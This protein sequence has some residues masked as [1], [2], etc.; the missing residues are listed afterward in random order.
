M[1]HSPC[2]AS[3]ASSARA[4]TPAFNNMAE[5]AKSLVVDRKLDRNSSVI[6]HL[7]Y[8]DLFFPPRSSKYWNIC[9]FPQAVLLPFP[10]HPVLAGR[11]P[12][13][14]ISPGTWI[15][16]SKLEPPHC[17]SGCIFCPLFLPLM[18][19]HLL[20]SLRP[21]CIQVLPLSNSAPSGVGHQRCWA[22]FPR[23]RSELQ[24]PWREEQSSGPTA[25]LSWQ[26]LGAN[27]IIPHSYS[28][29]CKQHWKIFLHI[30]IISKWFVFRFAELQPLVLQAFLPHRNVFF[31][32]MMCFVWYWNPSFS[33]MKHDCCQCFEKWMQ[34][35]NWGT[36]HVCIGFNKEGKEPWGWCVTLRSLIGMAQVTFLPPV[37]LPGSKVWAVSYCIWV[38]LYFDHDTWDSECIRGVV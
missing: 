6:F 16:D 2:T 4:A 35:G 15:H 24:K 12:C 13:S 17:L 31:L 38:L 11:I 32:C 25:V 19:N 21:S 1:I 27:L 22:A 26:K 10:A 8:S 5:D 23:D 3:V 20:P 29:Y 34:W 14:K 33:Q 28:D 9:N 30:S 36:G 7:N 37:L 18:Q